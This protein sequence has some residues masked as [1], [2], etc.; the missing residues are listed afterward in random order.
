MYLQSIFFQRTLKNVLYI[1]KSNEAEEN[2]GA[3]VIVLL[4][5]G[6]SIIMSRLKKVRTTHAWKSVNQIVTNLD[7]K[8]N[9]RL[10]PNE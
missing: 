4:L 8:I 10:I 3:I 1:N 7:L 6:T 9:Q 5:Q 2:K